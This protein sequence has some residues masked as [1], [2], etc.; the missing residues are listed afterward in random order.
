MEQC[1]NRAFFW[2]VSKK[3]FIKEA[4]RSAV[5][6]RKHMPDIDRVIFTGNVNQ[7]YK[8]F[9]NVYKLPP[10]KYK[11]WFLKNVH[12]VNYAFAK[13]EQYDKLIFLDSDTYMLHPV[14][15]IFKALDRYDLVA[16][17]A[18]GRAVCKVVTDVPDVIPEVNIGV[19]GI[20]NNKRMRRFIKEWLELYKKHRD[21]Y[22]N[23]DQGSLRDMLW[24][25][26]DDEFRYH[27][28]PPEYNMRTI[29]G[30]FACYPVKIIHGRLKC[31]EKVAKRMNKKQ[32]LRSW[33]RGEIMKC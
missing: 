8:E 4:K 20:K 21:I 18:P 29:C 12:Y 28:M 24:K 14:Y 10:L 9:D 5:T 19:I 7:P 25:F 23:N 11:L 1:T 2:I 13:F 32:G 15:D 22:R 27:I 17:H 6:C 3:K 31:Y 16:A 33:N 26:D 30:N